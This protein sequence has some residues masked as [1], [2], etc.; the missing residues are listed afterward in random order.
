AQ[1]MA[2]QMEDGLPGALNRLRSTWEETMLQINKV[3]APVLEKVVEFAI[4]VIQKFQGMSDSTKRLI[5]VLGGIT[6]AIGPIL[7]AGGTLLIWAGSLIKTIGTISLTIGKLGG[8]SKVFA[9][10]TGAVKGLGVA[11]GFLT[12]PVGIA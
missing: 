1:R 6:A 7:V 2:E 8:L 3:I 12:G 9:P 5:V 11:F 4:K 10:L